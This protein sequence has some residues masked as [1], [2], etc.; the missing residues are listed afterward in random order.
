MHINIKNL[1]KLP[2]AKALPLLLVLKQA[3]KKDRSEEVASLIV[4][5]EDLDR[6][7][8]QGY[9]KYIKGKK[10][11]SIIHKMRLGKKGTA[12]LNSLEDPDVEEED[13][14]IFNWLSEIYK[15]RDK[16]IGNGKKTVRLIASFR[17]KSGIE[18]N[19]L[20][21][22]CNTFINDDS[23]Q[24]YSHK[25]EFVFWKPKNI[26]QVR[27]ILED[28]RLWSYYQ[29]KKKWFDAQFKTLKNG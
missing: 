9:I 16:Q 6:L 25:L 2:D 18:K 19:H 13:V 11:D 29:K 22:L 24:E 1:F 5:D 20:A 26:F 23:E 4:S 8:K 27:F 3:S 10:S 7:E 28:S 17:E 12:F 21:F 14:R 15:K